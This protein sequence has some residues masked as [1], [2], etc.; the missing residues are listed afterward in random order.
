MPRI[1][2]VDD[3]P[4][5]VELVSGYLEREGW[6][7]LSSEDGARHDLDT[8]LAALREGLA[9]LE[10]VFVSPPVPDA[11]VREVIEASCSA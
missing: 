1:L 4:P 2:V 8:A 3:E 6:E 11:D 9:V 10:P 5:I 7:A